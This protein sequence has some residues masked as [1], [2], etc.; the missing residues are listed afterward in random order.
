M[1]KKIKVG[2]AGY[3]IS[4]KVFHIPFIT[5]MEEYELVTVLERSKNESQEKF[6]QVKIARSIDELVA[7]P[8]TDLIVI[9]TP[10][11]THFPYAAK[12]LKAGKHVVLEKP[13]TNTIEE[14]RELIEIGRSSGKVFS[15]YQN[16]RYVNDFMTIKDLL[17]QNVLGDI[18]E[19][20]ANYDRY[21]A[22]PRPNAWREEPKIGS[23]ILY[24]LGPHVIDQALMLFGHPKYITA[25]IRSQRPHAR[26]DD[27]FNIWLDYGFTKVVLHSGMLI[28]EPGPRYMVQGTKGSYI[29]YGDDPQEARLREGDLPL[30]ED[31]GREAEEFDGLLHTEIDGQVVRKKIPSLKGNF[32]L[33]YKNLY[34]SI[35]N[36]APLQ[37]RPEHGYNTIRIIELA[38]E[39]KRLS[40]TIECSGL[41]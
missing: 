8:E 40:K 14:A 12:A 38:F 26:V 18:H 41:L 37:E 13:F 34:N 11:D 28:R 35:V 3:G 2:V 32:G 17:S 6:P 23:G 10:N 24:D 25:D 16:R 36:G 4:A 9:T 33:Y 5:T 39:S 22:E 27:Y 19:F 30:G 15:V 7:D 1:T 20:S 31:W 29:K 21:R